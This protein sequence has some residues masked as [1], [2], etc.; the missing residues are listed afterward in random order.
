VDLSRAC[1]GY[2]LVGMQAPEDSRFRSVSIWG[3]L[4]RDVSPPVAR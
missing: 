3:S 4:G 1:I 2:A